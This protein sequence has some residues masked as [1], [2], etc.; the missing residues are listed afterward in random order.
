MQIGHQYN[1]YH[2][3]SVKLEP[4]TFKNTS[5]WELKRGWLL[6]KGRVTFLI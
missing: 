5:F 4:G 3:D 1:Q 6:D 2:R